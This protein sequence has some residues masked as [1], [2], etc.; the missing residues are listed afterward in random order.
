[1]ETLFHDF[2]YALRLQR[3]SPGFAVTAILTLALGM[4]AN[5][6]MF[7]RAQH[8]AADER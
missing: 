8:G 7:S 1:M 3:K 4:S 6:V 5:T 2:R